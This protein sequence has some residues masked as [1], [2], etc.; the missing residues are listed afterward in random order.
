MSRGETFLP[1]YR[2]RS[3][4]ACRKPLIK[5]FCQRLTNGFVRHGLG[6]TLKQALHN[7]V[8]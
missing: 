5:Q 7:E 8:S 3:T 4:S 2:Y 6:A 1:I